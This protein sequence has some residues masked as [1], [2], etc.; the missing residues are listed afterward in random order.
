MLH[1]VAS[2][3]QR[4]ACYDHCRLPKHGDTSYPGFVWHDGL[5][6]MSYYASHEGKTAIY[7][8]KIALD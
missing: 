1:H 3:L 8:A 7:L 6:W 2:H 4:G 5:L